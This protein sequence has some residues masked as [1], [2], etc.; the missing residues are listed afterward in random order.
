MTSS[1]SSPSFSSPAARG[2]ALAVFFVFFWEEDPFP[3]PPL[4]IWVGDGRFLALESEG[5]CCFN[6]VV[7]RESN[8]RDGEIGVVIRAGEI[9]PE[10]D[11]RAARS[12][13]SQE[14]LRAIC[15]SDEQKRAIEAATATGGSVA[16][17]GPPHAR[18][19]TDTGGENA[20]TPTMSS[21]SRTPRSRVGGS[22]LKEVSN[23]Q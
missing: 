22:A 4:E 17:A 16:S 14:A 12:E 5:D 18:I 20:S 1:F 6:G 8:A 7:L 2:E 15:L 10:M 3:D 21:K 9:V 23:L 19:S 11:A 13:R